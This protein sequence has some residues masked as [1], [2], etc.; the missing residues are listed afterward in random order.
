MTTAS[1]IANPMGSG[2]ENRPNM[3]IRSPR[4]GF[5]GGLLVLFDTLP[6]R[7]GF[8]LGGIFGLGS[9]S[10]TVPG[11]A[12]GRAPDRPGRLTGSGIPCGLAVPGTPAE[13]PQDDHGT[14][15]QDDPDDGRCGMLPV[16]SGSEN[17]HFL[18]FTRFL[19]RPYGGHG[20]P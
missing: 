2:T 6:L 15:D 5:Q 16:S 11:G 19:R 8:L 9:R 7:A 4:R 18:S 3:L 12:P 14:A 10:L 20:L 1:T 13:E 17:V